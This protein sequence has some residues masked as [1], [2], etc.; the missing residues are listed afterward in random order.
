MG[1]NKTSNYIKYAIGEIVLVVIGILIALQINNWNETKK[2]IRAERELLEVVL[3]NIRTDSLSLDSIIN[4]TDGIIRVH[5]NLI[6]LSKDEIAEEEVGNLDAVR[7]SE[8]N[9]AITRKNNPNLSNEVRDLQLKK[10]ILDYYLAIDWLESSIHYNN[11]IIE[12]KVRPFLA[13]KKLLNYG[14]QFNPP[15]QEMNLVN[16]E[17]FLEEFQNEELKQLLFEAGNK[18]SIMRRVTERALRKNDKVKIA[19]INYLNSS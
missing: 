5:K 4:R 16:T 9:Q 18:L 7:R 10:I 19:I 11:E 2:E 13:K 14:N 15:N 12:Q 6:A 1:Q 3:E 8:F 17:R